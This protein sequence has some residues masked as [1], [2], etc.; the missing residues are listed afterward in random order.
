MEREGDGG[1]RLSISPVFGLV[2]TLCDQ[3]ENSTEETLCECVYSAG[4]RSHDGAQP[5]LSRNCPAAQEVTFSLVRLWWW[6]WWWGCYL[7]LSAL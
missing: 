7:S 1:Q 4:I 5:L 3:D 6:W 2:F